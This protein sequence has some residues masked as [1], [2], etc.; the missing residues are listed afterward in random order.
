M[1]DKRQQNIIMNVFLSEFTWLALIFQKEKLEKK[2]SEIRAI[3]LSDSS[4]E[5]PFH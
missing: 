3:L 2:N 1:I 5:T 4:F